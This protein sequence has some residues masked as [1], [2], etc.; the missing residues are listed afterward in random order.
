MATT[1][2]IS[3]FAH[4]LQILNWFHSFV[5]FTDYHYILSNTPGESDFVGC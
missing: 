3:S 2:G 5:Q 4:F 1:Q